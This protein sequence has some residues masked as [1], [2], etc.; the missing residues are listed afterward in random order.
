M[1]LVKRHTGH[2]AFVLLARAIHIE[3]AKPSNLG[4]CV[5]KAGIRRC[6]QLFAHILVKQQLA[7]AIQIQRC[8][9]H[10]VFRKHLAVAIH[11]CRR[12]IE[13]ARAALLA[14][15]EQLARAIKIIGHHVI[16][17]GFHR[18]AA[19]TLV[20]HGFDLAEVAPGKARVEI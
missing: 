7:L 17:A 12:S 3:I 9:V 16:V 2:A 4:R 5:S 8:F 11:R 15:F 18:V 10:R 6:A 20:Q 13:Q 19:S 14:G 1:K